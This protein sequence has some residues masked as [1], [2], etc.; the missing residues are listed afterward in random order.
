MIRIVILVLSGILILTV[1][2]APLL[3][4]HKARVL[5]PVNEGYDPCVENPYDCP[6]YKQE[7]P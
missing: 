7:A 6:Q 1:L 3:L 4:P 5:V 2:C